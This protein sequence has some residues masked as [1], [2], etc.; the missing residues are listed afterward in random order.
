MQIRV[1]AAITLRRESLQLARG[2]AVLPGELTLQVGT[3]LVVKVIQGLQWA[4]ID[5]PGHKVRLRASDGGKLIDPRSMAATSVGSTAAG[6]S[7]FR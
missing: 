6:L 2:M 1:D 3:S 7:A 5:E 4:T